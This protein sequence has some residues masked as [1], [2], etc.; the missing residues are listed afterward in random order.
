MLFF[1]VW[2][3]FS[4]I[5]F[6]L[7]FPVR[8][9]RDTAFHPVVGKELIGVRGQALG[10]LRAVAHGQQAAGGQRLVEHVEQRAR[11]AADA[12]LRNAK[13]GG[14][15]RLQRIGFEIGQQAEKLRVGTGQGRIGPL[16]MGRDAPPGAVEGVVALMPFPTGRKVGEQVVKFG[17]QQT[18]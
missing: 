13:A 7:P 8:V 9:A 18:G 6:F 5:L 2:T 3:F 15:V 16:P 17:G 1:K 14:L 11:Q 10:Q 12:G 4:T